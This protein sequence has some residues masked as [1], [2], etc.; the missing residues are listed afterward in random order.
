MRD[1]ADPTSEPEGRAPPHAPPPR[2]VAADFLPPAFAKPRFRL[3]AAG[4]ALSVIGSWIQQVA[5]GWLV[6]RLTNSVFLLGFTGFLLQ[7]PHLFIAPF[8]GVLS[9]RLP[10]STVL[11]AVNVWLAI[12]AA[13][14]AVLALSGVDE[15]SIYLVIAL[16]IGIGNACEAPTRQAILGAIIEDRALLPSAIG[17]NSVLFNTGR[18]IGPAIAGVLLSRFSEGVCFAAN[19]VSFIGIIGALVAM[20]LPE[21]QSLS[22]RAS[23]GGFAIRATFSQLSKLPVARYMLPSASAVALCAL[24]LNQLMPS[25][26]VDYFGGDAGLLGL[27]LSSS[28]AGALVGALFLSM[29]RG[30]GCNC[31]LARSLRLSPVSL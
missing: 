12:M 27:L 4:Q 29:Q 31:G 19:A 21:T 23:S 11:M 13:L 26:A 25:L 14:L 3:F 18:M 7:I 24:P 17:F 30:H 1:P 2:R 15:I 20:R 22:L 28:G 9:D 10:R 16:L 8:A 5:L 6:F